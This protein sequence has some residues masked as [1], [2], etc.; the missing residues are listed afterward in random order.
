MRGE[1]IKLVDG[2]T[3][4]RAFTYIDDGIDCILR[5]IE[6]RDGCA[7]RRIFNIGHPGNCV[8]VADLARLIVTVAAEFPELE[9]RAHRT[10]IVPV[11]AD[12]YYGQGY[13]DIQVRVPA[14]E[15]A[16]EYLGWKPTTDLR[17]AIRQTI[18]YYVSNG[19][20]TLLAPTLP[21]SQAS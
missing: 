19:T 15:A 11:S 20:G 5:I 3:Q 21:L 6:N 17:S 4:K 8:S 18:A 13:Q 16:R 2:G 14:I 9:D 1:P 7:S 10:S 12:Q